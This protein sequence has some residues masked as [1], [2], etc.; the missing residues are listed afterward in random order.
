MAF[1]LILTESPEPGKDFGENVFFDNL[2]SDYK[3]YVFSYPAEMPDTTLEDKLRELGNITGNNLFVNIGRLAD[4]QHDKIVKLFGVKNY[5]VI[6][7][8]AIDALASPAQDYFTAYARLDSKHL[9]NSPEKTVECVQKLFNLF[10]QGK[11]SEAIAQAKWRQRTEL[12]V[13]LTHFFTEPLKALGGFIAERDISISLLGG[14][15]EL[16]RSGG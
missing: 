6:I 3:V 13:W 12:V 7:V 15:I 11:V 8:T 2:P 14:K 1:R 9:L 5:P 4:P 16:K 10:I